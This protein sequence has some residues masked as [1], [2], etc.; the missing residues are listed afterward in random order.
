MVTTDPTI[1][2]IH[3]HRPDHLPHKSPPTLSH[4]GHRNPK[5]LIAD[6]AHEIASGP[7]VELF[8]RTFDTDGNGSI[9]ESEVVDALRL[10]TSIKTER[11]RAF[12]IY[13]CCDLDRDGHVDLFDLISVLRSVAHFDSH[14]GSTP[15]P[16]PSPVDDGIGDVADII[17]KQFDQNRDGILDFDEFEAMLYHYGALRG[18]SGVTPRDLSRLPGSV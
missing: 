7:M 8:L 2:R 12:L 10:L 11:D 16:P 15:T 3:H 14:G 18:P 6:L 9:S 4:P 1:S 5:V 17:F 13:N